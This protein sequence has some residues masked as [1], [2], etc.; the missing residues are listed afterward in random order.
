MLLALVANIMRKEGAEP[1]GPEDFYPRLRRAKKRSEWD[2]PEGQH[3]L[4]AMVF[5]GGGF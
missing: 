4:A 1:L 2:T 3:R 5:G